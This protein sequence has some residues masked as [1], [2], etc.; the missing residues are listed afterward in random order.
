[1]LCARSYQYV[2]AMLV[3]ISVGVPT[4]AATVAKDIILIEV[5]K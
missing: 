4:F 3:V 1:M 5:V 2:I